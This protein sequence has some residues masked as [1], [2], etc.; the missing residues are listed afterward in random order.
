MVFFSFGNLAFNLVNSESTIDIVVAS[1]EK[2][3]DA[4]SF[5]DSAVLYLDEKIYPGDNIKQ[6]YEG[7][8]L[9]DGNYNDIVRHYIELMDQKVMIDFDDI[10]KIQRIKFAYGGFLREDFIIE[11]DV[12]FIMFS[13][14]TSA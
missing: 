6:E 7:A 4:N 10:Q 13:W 3:K 1:K 12:E 14:S 8:V 9:K 5:F 11:T 2:Y